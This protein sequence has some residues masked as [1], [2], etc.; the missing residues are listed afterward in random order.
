MLLQCVG[1]PGFLWNRRL[2]TPGPVI[3]STMTS[4]RILLLSML[5]FLIFLNFLGPT[6][7]SVKELIKQ[8]KC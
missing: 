1:F 5:F 2:E 4:S 7:Q 6:K 3:L 8:A